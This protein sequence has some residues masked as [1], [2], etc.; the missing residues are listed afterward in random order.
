MVTT[1][2]EQAEL[3]KVILDTIPDVV[4]EIDAEGRFVFLSGAIKS[5]G[6]QPQE[7]INRH[8]KD[9]VHPEDYE[10]VSR[11]IVLPKYEGKRTGDEASPKLFDERRT[12]TRMTK[13]LIVRFLAKDRAKDPVY[14]NVSSSGKWDGVGASGRTSLIGSIGI[15]RDVTKEIELER[16]KEEFIS[17]VTHELRAPLTIMK[18][19]VAL[20]LDGIAGKLNEK[21]KKI[22]LSNK[23]SMERLMRI[24]NGLLDIAK[25][26]AGKADLYREKIDIGPMLEIIVSSFKAAVKAKG[27]DLKVKMEKSCPPVYAD[28]DKLTQVFVNLLSNALKFTKKG[29]IELSASKAKDGVVFSVEDSG[30]GIPVDKQKYIF[31]KFNE[32]KYLNEAGEKGSGLGLSIAKGIV[33][34]HGG[35]IKVESAPS[36]GSKFT[37]SIPAY[38]ANAALKDKIGKAVKEAARENGRVSFIFIEFSKGCKL[39]DKA[40]DVLK[41]SLHRDGD[42]RIKIDDKVLVVLPNCR[43]GGVEKVKERLSDVLAAMSSL[44]ALKFSMKCAAYPLDGKDVSGIV[45]KLSK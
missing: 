35:S 38:S 10:K 44:E 3:Y 27:L 42:D 17:I 45:S 36:K 20:L 13:N 26:E 12:D 11:A 32:L 30:S 28:R 18:E 8:F 39:V 31:S 15:I 14:V 29:Y 40:F 1:T 41:N 19:G 25:I 7:L 23:S 33:E 9:I 24:V 5:L 43:D 22:L 16:L 6:Y 4:Y 37:F 34:M 2:N 21:Q